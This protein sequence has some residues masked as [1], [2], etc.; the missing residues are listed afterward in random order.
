MPH[1]GRGRRGLVLASASPRRRH[2]L[3]L[4]G[5]PFRVVVAEIDEAPRPGETPA[6]LAARL[7]REKALAVSEREPESLVLAADTVVALGAQTLGK[8]NDPDD[9][10]QMLRHL[11][12]RPHEVLTGLALARDGAIVHQSVTTT[13]VWMREYTDREIAEYVASERPLDKAGAY[14]V[15]DVGFRPAARLDGCYPNVVGLPLCVAWRALCDAGLPVVPLS[16]LDAGPCS[17]G[18]G[19]CGLCLRAAE[20]EPPA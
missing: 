12:G 17:P 4:L 10:V 9:A 15:Q 2:L 14:G 20:S 18:S 7:G 3:S 1:D 19:P 16:E 5:L 11:R 6:A 13:T 8:P